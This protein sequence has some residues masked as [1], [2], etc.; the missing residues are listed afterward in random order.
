M[1]KKFAM[2]AY[3]R[4]VEGAGEGGAAAS[5]DSA[6]GSEK[7]ANGAGS[8]DPAKLPDDHPLVKA[9]A[10]QKDEIKAL[11]GRSEKLAEI[12][13]ANKT[14]IQRATEAATAAEQRA[15]EAEA[16][17]LRRDVALEVGLSK[18]DAAYLDAL[19]DEDA[20]RALAGRLA[21]AA[22]TKEPEAPRPGFH[23]DQTGRE[24]TAQPNSD[25]IARAF[26]GI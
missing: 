7:V 5:S 11:R 14:E 20:M 16:R 8:A 13:D 17:A 24:S 6:E 2:P 22:A 18:D 25:E 26:L 9:Y 19:T 12:E 3:V 4:F 23:M 1:H 15:A 21:K 10:A